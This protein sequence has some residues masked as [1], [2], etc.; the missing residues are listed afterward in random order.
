MEGETVCLEAGTFTLT[1]E[2][3]MARA[4]QTLKGAG[5]HD[6]ILDFSS[7]TLGA[8][9]INITADHVTVRAFEVKNT[10]GDGIRATGVHNITFD[11][12]S[13]LWEADA[14]ESNGAYGLYPVQSDGVVVRNCTVKGASDAG[15]YVGQSFRILVE[16]NEVFGNVA[17]IEIE[18]STEAEVRHNHAHDN[19]GGILVF[20][21][22]N[23]PVKN[24]SRARVHNNLIEN[25]NLVNF[26][27]I[28]NIVGQVPSGSG[29][30]VLAS[31]DNEFHDNTVR[32]NRSIGIALVYYDSTVFGSHDDAEFD[33]YC[34]GNFVHD[35]T[36][37]NNGYDPQGVMTL[38][39]EDTIAPLAWSG[40]VDPDKTDAAHKN[41]FMGN[42]D[43]S[44]LDFDLCG[45]FQDKSVDP[46]EVTCEHDSLDVADA[47]SSAL[48]C[49]DPPA[50]VRETP[51]DGQCT[52][53]FPRLSDY[54]FFEG[55]LKAL[56][57]AANVVPY[58][59]A[60]PLWSDGTDKQ[61]F[62]VL[63]G[64]EKVE[65]RETDTYALPVGATL[66][67]NFGDGATN[68][69]TRLLIHTQ[70]G[71]QGQVYRWNE[72]QTEAF[73]MVA[74][75]TTTRDGGQEYIVPNT[76]MCGD[77]HS[78]SDKLVPLGTNTR[79]LNR[80]VDRG[81]AAV[82]Q[83]AWLA[84]Q[85]V[86]GASPPAADTLDAHPDPYGEDGTVDARARA[87]LD[88]NCA[89]CHSPGGLAEA[90]GLFLGAG[91][92]DDTKLGVCK[93]PVA[94]G[95]GSGGLKYGIVPGDPDASILAFRIASDDPAVKMP[96]LPNLIVDEPG[97][98]LIRQWI[99]EM[100][101]VD[102]DAATD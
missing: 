37:E 36:F 85:G 19:T 67:K 79:Q 93:T 91:E 6:T 5:K 40:C 25:N 100:D 58:D 78:S 51:T 64:D 38:I 33:A 95:A 84:D 74:G 32:N 87:W 96:E 45:G 53:P 1:R 34:Q 101:S 16:D 31:D 92:T 29:I 102:C 90:T 73:R 61:R 62:V 66:I 11:D 97:V 63:P 70:N 35:N 20:N 10:P 68:I 15:I 49:V 43:A 23:L 3:R 47:C 60:A 75:E 24:G 59:V 54:G 94:A 28:G 42:G 14:A 72:E 22:P 56:S 27:P 21:L 57:P 50:I 18:N 48:G 13:I 41:C 9:G 71:W 77:C 76:L 7:Q 88:A 46:A 2:L 4:H 82:D 12:V 80:K 86:F 26:A 83:L 65:F 17:G 44:Y 89:H 55:E 98:A 99:T 81:G 8:N 52:V 30:I 69:E 39:Q